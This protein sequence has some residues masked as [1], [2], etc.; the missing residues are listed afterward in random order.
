MGKEKERRMFKGRVKEESLK[1]LKGKQ[2][3]RKIIP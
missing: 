3:Q 2:R 1:T